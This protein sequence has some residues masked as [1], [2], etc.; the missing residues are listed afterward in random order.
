M[1]TNV[2]RRAY[3]RIGNAYMKMNDYTNAVEY[4]GKSLTEHRTADIL[5][6]L[7]KVSFLISSCHILLGREV[8][9]GS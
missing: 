1:H 8:E 7:K 5:T 2:I 4:Y 3:F 9:G 6:A